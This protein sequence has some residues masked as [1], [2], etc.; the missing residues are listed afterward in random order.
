MNPR[1]K[2]PLDRSQP[3]QRSRVD[4]LEGLG[5]R[6]QPDAEFG[7]SVGEGAGTRVRLQSDGCHLRSELAVVAGRALDGLVHLAS[8][9]AQL[10]GN[11][12]DV[13]C[14][15]AQPAGINADGGHAP[16]RIWVDPTG[17]NSL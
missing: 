15:L 17:A 6:R 12:R 3:L 11:D 5:L 4:G 16:L 9:R 14:R 2:L 1:Q 13:V 10:L 8:R 7:E